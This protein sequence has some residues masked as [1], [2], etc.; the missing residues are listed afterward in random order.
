M[1][2]LHNE[3]GGCLRG[4]RRQV[5][6][7]QQQRRGG[8]GGRWRFGVTMCAPQRRPGGGGSSAHHSYLLQKGFGVC[9][10]RL[11]CA[12]CIITLLSGSQQQQQQQQQAMRTPVWMGCARMDGVLESSR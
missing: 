2:G 11:G 4:S 9:V 7:R 10:V 5:P 8:G 6:V 3:K 1:T 12:P